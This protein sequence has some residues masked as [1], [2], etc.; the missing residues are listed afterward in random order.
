MEI[1]ITPYASD[2]PAKGSML[3]KE[4]SNIGTPILDSLV[5]ESI[6]NSLDAANQINKPVIMKFK[7]GDFEKKQLFAQCEKLEQM[8]ASKF[9]K[10]P[11][12]FLSF[13]DYN[14][15]GLTGDVVDKG[16][17]N[18]GNYFK[19]V[20][21]I[22]N[23][24]TSSGAG[25]SCG[26]GKSLY[27]RIGVKGFVIFYSRIKLEK[28]N[29]ESRLIALMV[30]NER[31]HDSVIPPAEKGKSKT[32][33]AY[34]GLLRNNNILPL[35][36]EKEIKD[37]LNIFD[38]EPYKGDET[39]TAVILPFIDEKSL[40]SHNKKTFVD[41]KDEISPTWRSSIS[42]FLE[43]SIQRWYFARLNNKKYKN[44]RWLSVSINDKTLDANNMLPCF[45][46]FQALYNRATGIRNE[47]L[48][49]ILDGNEDVVIEEISL[50]RYKPL[51]NKKTG[52]LAYIM[53]DM[54]LLGML[55][56]SNN[57]SPYIYCDTVRQDNTVNPP[58][59]GY[60][61][62]PGMIVNYETSGDWLYR[63][64]NS[65]DNEHFLLALFVLNSK[66][67][68]GD[69]D[70]LE[71]YVRSVEPNDHM[72]WIDGEYKGE[73]YSFIRHTKSKVSQVLYR[74]LSA[75]EQSE[76]PK[77]MSELGKIY[78]WILPPEDFGKKSSPRPT[79]SVG[80][81]MSKP[82]IGSRLLYTIESQE[83]DTDNIIIT[84]SLET[85]KKRNSFAMELLV[86]TTD[87][88]NIALEDWEKMGADVPFYIQGAQISLKKHEGKTSSKMFPLS[89][90]KLE[91]NDEQI[92]LHVKINKTTG[93]SVPYV[94]N[95]NFDEECM[96]KVE[97]KLTI[98]ISSRTA[99][100]TINIV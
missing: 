15:E 28:G 100:P 11:E 79:S 61:R 69:D 35:T 29:Y 84:Y 13:R 70:Y 59:I 17:Q 7:T 37:V 21:D 16:D 94:L 72:R 98:K 20:K 67:K 46:I 96:F 73:N 86:S 75:E 41:E 39:G 47:G 60:C 40:L 10:I 85:L 51:A 27:F 3:M 90:S 83:L 43:I 6:Q 76:S 26:V 32:G 99:L 52:T 81:G 56:P 64:P 74:N 53:A 9:P 54:K 62:K 49:D 12:H 50:G 23:E 97:V 45:K 80:S 71:E 68:L 91:F 25:G 14:T 31:E 58:I 87:G 89:P 30:E 82:K 55:P 44:G 95:F 78:S 4:F 57:Y 36:K 38:I 48:E 66:N 8:L 5:R 92:G 24:Q 93:K 2:F 65:P 77:R 18:P 88:K 33:I 34:W 42:E 22:G 1:R 19:L 63:V